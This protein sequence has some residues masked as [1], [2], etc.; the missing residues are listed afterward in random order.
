LR[1]GRQ[2]CQQ[3]SDRDPEQILDLAASHDCSRL[4]I[5]THRGQGLAFGSRLVELMSGRAEGYAV[6]A[7]GKLNTILE[8]DSEPT[9]VADRLAELGIIACA[10]SPDLVKAV[11]AASARSQVPV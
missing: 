6:Y 8:G 7:G 4:A 1:L 5:L 11:A 2:G 10:D 3:R 9:D